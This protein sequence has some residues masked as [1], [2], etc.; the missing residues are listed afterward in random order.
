MR[1]VL[2]PN[3]NII[4]AV[5]SKPPQTNTDWQAVVNA[6][7]AIQGAASPI[8]T[9]GRMRSNGQPAP[10][11]ATDYA[12]FASALGPAGKECQK[13]ALARDIEAIGN[14]TDTL[15]EACDNCHKVYRDMPQAHSGQ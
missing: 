15:S 3:S 8:M 1:G 2:L 14:C 12:R 11:Q 6:A 9:P 10:V 7:I 5:Q 4:F 13:A